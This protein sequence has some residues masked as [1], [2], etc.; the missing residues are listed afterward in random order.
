MSATIQGTS[1]SMI[2]PNEFDAGLRERLQAPQF[3]PF[4]VE[5]DNGE[6][7]LIREPRLAFGG[8]AAVFIDP[9][10]GGFVDFSHRE[11]TGFKTA[12]NEVGA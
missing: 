12:S 5:L 9:V 2:D 1:L 4:Y 3:A 7:I 6:R 8:G 10:E 11:T